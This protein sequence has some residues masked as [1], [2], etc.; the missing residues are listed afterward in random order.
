MFDAMKHVENVASRRVQ[1]SRRCELRRGRN[2]WR[3]EANRQM[4]K[5]NVGCRWPS[6]TSRVGYASGEAQRLPPLLGALGQA[7][8]N[9]NRDLGDRMQDVTVVTMSEFGRTVRGKRRM[10]ATIPGHCE[11]H[12]PDGRRD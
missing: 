4:I 11:L 5:A 2:R 9:F 10:A 12:V 1:A 6:S 8:A 7:L 3:H